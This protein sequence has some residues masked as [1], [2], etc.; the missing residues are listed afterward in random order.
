[1]S[2]KEKAVSLLKMAVNS[3]EDNLY[4]AKQEFRNLTPQQ[5]QERYYNSE[6]TKQQILDACEKE[7]NE[8]LVAIQFV[9]N[10]GE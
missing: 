7:Y 2:P 4:R 6:F 9:K 10:I 8:V 1:M 3:A 5:M